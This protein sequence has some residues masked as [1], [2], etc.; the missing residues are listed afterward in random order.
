MIVVDSSVLID[1]LAGARTREVLW[2]YAN[3]GWQ[4]FGITT[5]VMAESLQG[6]RGDRQFHHAV[7]VLATLT[8]FDSLS[9]ELAQKAALNYRALRALGVTV[10]STI[11]CLLATFC[12]EH[13]YRLL[14][15]DADFAPFI[16]H[17]GLLEVDT[18]ALPVQ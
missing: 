12:I 7:E 6:I 3:I 10:H 1:F 15:R 18:L 2:L 17:F 13:S 16:Q 14:H 11:D 9:A 5:T 8:V 4:P